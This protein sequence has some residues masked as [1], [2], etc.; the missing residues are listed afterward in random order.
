MK[1]YLKI[2]NDYIS[3]YLND[4]NHI[5]FG[6]QIHKTDIFNSLK[7]IRYFIKHF[8]SLKTTCKE[9]EFIIT[10]SKIIPV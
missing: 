9:C 4:G 8:K 1:Y 10:N 7:H 2:R 3:S 5:C 6:S